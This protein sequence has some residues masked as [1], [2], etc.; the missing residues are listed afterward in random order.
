MLHR[1]YTYAPPGRQG[2]LSPSVLCRPLSLIGFVVYAPMDSGNK[3]QFR[4]YANHRKG[5]VI[6][7]MEDFFL[8]RPSPGPYTDVRFALLN[9]TFGEYPPL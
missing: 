4:V 7:R 8:F 9:V 6:G 3:F 5:F 2:D 1:Y